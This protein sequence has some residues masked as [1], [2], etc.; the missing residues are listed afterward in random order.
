[1][2][3]RFPNVSQWRL[4]FVLSAVLV[5][6]VL[7]SVAKVFFNGLILGLDYGLY[8]PDGAF[9][10][11]RALLFAGYDKFE[12][13]RIVADWYASQPA[14]PG[15]L[16]PTSLFFENAPGTWDQYYP[17][18]LYPLISAIFVKF[19]GVPGMLVVP[20]V[21]YLVVLLLTSYVAFTKGRSGVGLLVIA[22][23]T[24]SVT[25]SRWMYINATDGLLMLFTGLFVLIA[26]KSTGLKLSNVQL[27]WT[28]VL[29][30]LS[31]LTRFS[32][33]MWVA[34]SLVFMFHR[35]IK[36]GLLILAT[37]A[38]TT[39]P[40]FLRPFGNDVLP[41]LNDKSPIEKLLLYPISLLK[42]SVFEIGQLFVLD[43][44]FFWT[45]VLAFG[46]SITSIRRL[47]AQFFLASFLSLWITGSLNA[48]LG[49]NFRY[50]LAVIPFLLWLL[51]S[52]FPN[53][54]WKNIKNVSGSAEEAS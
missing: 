17:R 23:I 38:L 20:A 45:L 16:D 48:V 53:I 4:S 46:I 11:F 1:M 33:L 43:R 13:G 25:I 8:H 22:L 47:E 6:W 15:R 12:A 26:F 2:K 3:V 10:T 24:S 51:V 49:V 27:M 32:A 35:R 40:I 14:K 31:S 9:Y 28:C 21:T 34:I 41:D 36:E 18:V 52:L 54:E 44:V 30:T 39:V 42:I 29:I 19:L 37:A 5:L 50:Q 7:V